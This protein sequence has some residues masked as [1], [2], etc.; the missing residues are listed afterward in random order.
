MGDG[1]SYAERPFQM[2]DGKLL[3]LSRVLFTIQF[4]GQMITF[5]SDYPEDTN[6][7]A[8]RH[9]GLPAV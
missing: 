9:T 8:W 7:E 6:A 1:S 2:R 5:A 4:P 3:L